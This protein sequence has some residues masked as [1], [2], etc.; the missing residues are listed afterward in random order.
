MCVVNEVVEDV[1]IWH[2]YMLSWD[3]TQ[4]M[5]VAGEKFLLMIFGGTAEILNTL[6]FSKVCQKVATSTE[7]VAP[8]SLCPTSR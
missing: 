2:W 7:V 4:Y 6:R 8:E 3:V 1:A 5:I